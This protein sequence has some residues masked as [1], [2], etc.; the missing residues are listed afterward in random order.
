MC[1]RTFHDFSVNLLLTSAPESVTPPD[2][3]SYKKYS[4]TGVTTM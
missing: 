3:P 1:V 4:G 2:L